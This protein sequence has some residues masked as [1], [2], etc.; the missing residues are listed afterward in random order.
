MW[1]WMLRTSGVFLFS[2]L[3][4]TSPASADTH[5]YI[6]FGAPAVYPGYVYPGYVYPGYVYP[7]DMHCGVPGWRRSRIV[8]HAERCECSLDFLMSRPLAVGAAGIFT[9]WISSPAMAACRFAPKADVPTGCQAV[10]A[11]QTREGLPVAPAVI[12][13][14]MACCRRSPTSFAGWLRGRSVEHLASAVGSSD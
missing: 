12:P 10:A 14:G 6:H 1:R 7:G 2:S 3:F 9:K 8:Y 4:L 11:A 5:L 13:I